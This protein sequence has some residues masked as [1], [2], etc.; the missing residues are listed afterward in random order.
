MKNKK[1]LLISLCFNILFIGL[2]LSLTYVYRDKLYQRFVSYKGNAKIVMFGNSITAQGIWVELLGRTDVVNSGLPGQCTFYFLQMIQSQVIDLH[3]EIC[4]VKGGINDITIGVAPEK[5]Q[6]NYKLILE[7]LAHNNIIP[8]V[9]LTFHEVNNPVSKVEVD[10]LNNFLITYCKQHQIS[11]LDLNGYLS[12]SSGLRP[13]FAV[14]QTHLNDKGYAIWAREIKKVL[15]E[16][17][18]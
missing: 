3:P 1:A 8:V 10:N 16:K 12:D 17:G 5:L 9:T 13:E 6:A 18:I 14:D 7:T 15:K 4:F 2:F 11:Y